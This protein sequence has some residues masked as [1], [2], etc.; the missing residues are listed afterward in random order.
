MYITVPIYYLFF[1][2]SNKFS[3][4]ICYRW[5]RPKFEN[6]VILGYTIQCWFNEIANHTDIHVC[7]ES[8]VLSDILEYKVY[9]LSPNVT[10]Y[11]QVRART[12]IGPGPYTDVIGVSTAYENPI[13]RLLVTTTEAVNVIDL[14]E[15]MNNY[16]IMRHI[17]VEIAFSAAEDNIFW[18]NKIQE[19]ILSDTRGFHVTKIF[20]LNN[21]AY[22]LCVD[23]I[24]K[25]LYWSESNDK[26]SES[27][28]LKLDL[29]SLQDKIVTFQ[30]IITRNG[31]I[32][33]LDILPSMG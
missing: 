15:K 6:G 20:T 2:F 28:I 26:E 21:T 17:A 22:S 9:N 8:N 16:T 1:I 18:I 33:K 24:A 30:P 19:L 27:R 13:P 32:I 5:N 29:S 4:F 3:S 11:F 7:D 25:Y 14:D 12:I 31:R 10:Y 23:W